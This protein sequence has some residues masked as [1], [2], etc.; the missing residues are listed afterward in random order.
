M[1]TGTEKNN[2]KRTYKPWRWEIILVAGLSLLIGG[3]G[4]VRIGG[5][6][7]DAKDAAYDATA[8]VDR[9]EESSKEVKRFAVKLRT[10]LIASCEENGNPLRIFVIGQARNQIRQGHQ[11]DYSL[12]FPN[13]DPDVLHDLIHR[14][15]LRTF[16]QLQSIQ[17]VDCVD[18]Y[19]HPSK[20]VRK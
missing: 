14:Q 7:D 13:I 6:A 10:G 1:E 17:P 11:T 4:W 5:V 16:R 2:R 9:A 19:T 12:F 18:V 15:N 20:G 3:I 8:A